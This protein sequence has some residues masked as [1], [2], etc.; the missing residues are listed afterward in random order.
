MAK[1]NFDIAQN[2]NDGSW[3]VIGDCGDNRHWIPVSGPMSTSDDART[4]MLHLI[5]ANAAARA[6]VLRWDGR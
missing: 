1:R 3:Y 6:E 2:P 5:K 4:Y